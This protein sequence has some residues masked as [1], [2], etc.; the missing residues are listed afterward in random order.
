[1]I[2]NPYFKFYIGE[3]LTGD[4]TICDLSTQAV[5]IQICCFYWSRQGSICLANVKQ[6]FKQNENEVNQLLEYEIIKTDKDENIYK[7]GRA[8]V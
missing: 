1:M 7:I 8:H 3:W 6:R 2:E 5:F 4:I